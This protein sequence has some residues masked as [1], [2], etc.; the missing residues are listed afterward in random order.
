MMTMRRVS[1][2]AIVVVVIVAVVLCA[3]LSDARQF[4]R[5]DGYSNAGALVAG[6]PTQIAA[7]STMANGASRVSRINT[8]VN[9]NTECWLPCDSMADCTALGLWAC[10]ALEL[11]KGCVAYEVRSVGQTLYAILYASST[12]TPSQRTSSFVIS[13]TACAYSGAFT[14]TCTALSS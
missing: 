1:V 11:T 8:T 13:G 14:E 6:C 7:L 10:D 5:Y 2:R 9:A 12:L 4:S 3:A